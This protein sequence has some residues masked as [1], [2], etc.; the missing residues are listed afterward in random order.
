[1]CVYI[2]S[3][4]KAPW[5][6]PW[7]ATKWGISNSCLVVPVYQLSSNTS[8]AVSFFSPL[9]WLGYDWRS[10]PLTG[11]EEG[12][13]CNHLGFVSS[14]TWLPDLFSCSSDWLDFW[15]EVSMVK[16]KNL[17][18]TG[19]LKWTLTCRVVGAVSGKLHCDISCTGSQPSSAPGKTAASGKHSE[20][21]GTQVTKLRPCC[22]GFP[23]LGGI[24]HIQ[25]VNC[26]PFTSLG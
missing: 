4:V 18:N 20:A 6:L 8:L 26:Q 17:A 23:Y 21:R 3:K 11:P 25:R 15:T 7:I 19:S 2:Y 24:G 10:L 9:R 22:T 12:S 5:I 14:G 13:K 1:M 16:W